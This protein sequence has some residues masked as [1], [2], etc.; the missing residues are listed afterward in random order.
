MLTIEDLRREAGGVPRLSAIGF[1]G[2][3]VATVAD[4]GAHVLA[5]GHDA[6]ESGFTTLELASHVAVLLSMVLIL[7][8]VVA[9]GVLT[10]RA[11]RRADRTRKDVA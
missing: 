3:L 1:G 2:L 9:D 7:V 5:A 6:H 11:R 4:V 8:G 10:A